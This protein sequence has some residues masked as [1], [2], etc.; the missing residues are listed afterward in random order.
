MMVMM[1][2]VM[3]TMTD[4]PFPKYL[5]HSWSWLS[6]T[7]WILPGSCTKLFGLLTRIRMVICW[8]S[9][10][11]DNYLMIIKII[12]SPCCQETFAASGTGGG[13]QDKVGGSRTTLARIGQLLIWR[14]V[15][16]IDVIMIMKRTSS[17]IIPQPSPTCSQ[18]A[19]NVSS[20]MFF[21]STLKYLF[22]SRSRRSMST[23]WCHIYIITHS[24]LLSCCGILAAS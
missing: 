21:L 11:G 12:W 19:S 22:K 24:L 3:V 20:T 2:T 5:G 14:A 4:T 9:D 6:P 15:I 10:D 23:F 13:G 8:L 7:P 1:M 18:S 16:M 17:Q